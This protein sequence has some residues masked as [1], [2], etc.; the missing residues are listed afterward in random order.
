M[1]FDSEAQRWSGSALGVGGRTLPKRLRKS[2]IK[3]K[4]VVKQC[5]IIFCNVCVQEERPDVD[6]LAA[7]GGDDLLRDHRCGRPG[8]APDNPRL[9]NLDQEGEDCQARL[10]GACS[11]RRSFRER[12]SA[13]SKWREIGAARTPPGTRAAPRRSLN[14]ALRDGEPQRAENVVS[15]T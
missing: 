6:V 8:G 2:R 13:C 15:A 7:G 3:C 9:A 12:S 5:F 11:A 4:V 14:S 10:S 1:G